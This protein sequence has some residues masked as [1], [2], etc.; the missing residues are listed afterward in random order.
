MGILFIDLPGGIVSSHVPDIT[1]IR[2]EESC[3][4]SGA[5][6]NCLSFIWGAKWID[7]MCTFFYEENNHINI[8]YSCHMGTRNL[9]LFALILVKWLSYQFQRPE[10]GVQFISSA[11]YLVVPGKLK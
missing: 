9:S 8:S 1:S 6:K 10:K 5:E 4:K 3:V 7:T 2:I 11:G